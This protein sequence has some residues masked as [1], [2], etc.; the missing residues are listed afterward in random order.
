MLIVYLRTAMSK[1]MLCIPNMRDGNAARSN[2]DR[3]RLISF[4][5]SQGDDGIFV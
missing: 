4:P 1:A 2:G 3:N 5:R